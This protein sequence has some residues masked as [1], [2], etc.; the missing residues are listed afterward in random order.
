MGAARAGVL[1]VDALIAERNNVGFAARA[2]SRP[3]L[4]PGRFSGDDPKFDRGLALIV[5][6][7]V[8]VLGWE[9]G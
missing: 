8:G 1:R 5:W 4:I 3:P 6:W 9:V 7:W 2:L